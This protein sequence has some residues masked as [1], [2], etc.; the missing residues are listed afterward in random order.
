MEQ[1]RKRDKNQENQPTEYQLINSLSRI[2]KE[3]SFLKQVQASV[4]QSTVKKAY[5]TWKSYLGLK[6]INPKKKYPNFKPHYRYNSFVYPQPIKKDGCGYEIDNSVVIKRVENRKL[7]LTLGRQN[8]HNVY[9]ETKI[10]MERNIEGDIKNLIIKRKNSKYYALFSCENIEPRLLPETNKKVGLDL[11][12][13][14]LITTSDGKKIKNPKFY[15]KSEQIIKE[16]N[17]SLS[18]KVKGSQ[19]WLDAK[20]QLAK[21]WEKVINQFKHYSYQEVN[22]LV[23]EYDD[24]AVEDLNVKG[25]LEK[26][27]G[28][29]K[30]SLRKSLASVKFGTL[31]KVISEKTSIVAQRLVRVNPRNTM[32]ICS[33]CDKLSKEK[34]GLS[35][36]IF[37]CW[38]CELKLDRDINSAK[39][40]LNLGFCENS[41]LEN[42][43]Y[44]IK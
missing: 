6:K 21:K 42:G 34:I 9:L 29:N 23:G 20:L 12:I 19:N 7:E 24:I 43:K 18:S 38:H 35:Q 22:K 37:T 11:G 5:K 1:F 39:N 40:I 14:T 33:N 26:K 31:L 3:N 16:A 13:R 8:N 25:M 36:K 41:P 30:R 10:K 2:K 32:Q 28:D 44:L 17:Q 15:Q 27:L 4:L